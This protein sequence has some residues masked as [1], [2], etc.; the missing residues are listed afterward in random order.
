MNVQTSAVAL[1]TSRRALNILALTRLYPL[2]ENDFA[3]QFNRITFRTLSDQGH[4]FEIVRCNC[5]C[6]WLL[7]P[8]SWRRLGS[9]SIPQSYRLDGIRVHCPR[10]WSPPGPWWRTWEGRW[11]YNSSINLVSEMHSSQ[12]FDIVFGGEL[13]PDGVTAVLI[14]R[15]LGL[16]VML[17]SIG[18]DAHKYPSRS[19]T[20]F[21]KTKWALENAHQ[22]LVESA[23]NREDI[24][25]IS[26]DC[27]PPHVFSRGIDLEVFEQ[28]HNV[29]AIR[30]ELGLPNDKRLIVFIGRVSEGKGVRVLV[31]AFER[32]SK[33]FSDVDLVIVGGGNLMRWTS[34]Y[35]QSTGWATRLHM[36]GVQPYSRVPDILRASN[37]F[38][39]P[40]YAEGL[41][42]SVLEAMAAG[43]PVVVTAVGG[44]PDVITNGQNG[45]LI[46]SVDARL[47]ESGLKSI[48][49]NPQKASQL[50]A[51]AKNT[52]RDR[53]DAKKNSQ[54]FIEYAW[55]AIE[56]YRKRLSTTASESLV[57]MI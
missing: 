30:K 39:L 6:P 48:L 40:S 24:A 49:V 54:Q 21:V 42:K 43:L 9:Q 15:A 51:H 34:E 27:V 36:L 2:A 56:T 53:F 35:A 28:E 3:G 12:P 52:V 22:I 44:L 33:A 45:L 10:F 7:R 13:T 50:A 31:R 17:S 1:E 11:Q 4:H 29:A 55:D 19:R 25:K 41:P 37:V 32:L 8:R 38:C 20:V 23:S 57:Q 5:R 14:G 18:S 26:V 47:L 16:P 46:E